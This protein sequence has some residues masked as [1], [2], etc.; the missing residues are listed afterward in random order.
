MK[1]CL[2]CPAA[3]PS[4]KGLARN[5]PLSN[6]PVFGKSLLEYW[7]EH[8]A[9]LGAKEVRI[10][11]ADRPDL[12]RQLAGT[13]EKWGLSVEVTDETREL[14]PV[15]ARV[16][17]PAPKEEWLPKPY[18]AVLM[19]HFPEQT[20]HPLFNSYAGWFFA[21][22]GWLSRAA[23]TN[24]IG[25]REVQPGVWVSMRARIADTAQLRAPCW[26]GEGARVGAR[27][28]IG[29]M[30]VVEDHVL[31]ESDC[32]ISG[33]HV[34]PDTMV[35]KFARLND[36]LAWGDMMIDRANGTLTQV[37]DP[38]IMCAMRRPT[39]PTK[40]ANWLEQLAAMLTQDGDDLEVLWKHRR[41]KLP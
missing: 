28:V 10:L 27:C 12:V 19:D 21:A 9:G 32:E 23:T 3:R 7:L 36:S 39:S 37:S 16:K 11:A 4:I 24:R 6:F 22:L 17:Y 5:V 38:F 1:T 34:G 26:I 20:Q 31:V 30:A 35:G 41:M 2:I 25:M 13:G 15:F 18:D 40:S 8:V 29:P 14:S 33:T